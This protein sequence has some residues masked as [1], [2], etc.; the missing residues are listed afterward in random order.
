MTFGRPCSIPQEYIRV[1][2][3]T[4]TCDPG[5]DMS[6]AFYNATMYVGIYFST[7]Y[8]TADLPLQTIV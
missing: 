6:V 2:L 7:L 3:P 1:G 8:S 4:P 5:G